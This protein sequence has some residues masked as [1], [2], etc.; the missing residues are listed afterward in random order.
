M[1][2]RLRLMKELSRVAVL[3][4]GLT[5]L[6]GSCAESNSPVQE[7]DSAQSP[8]PDA[9]ELSLAVNY[10]YESSPGAS[11]SPA[12]CLAGVVWEKNFYTLT[13]RWNKAPRDPQP[14]EALEGVV[15]PG[16]N[17]TGGNLEPDT[18]VDAWTIEGVDSEIAILV[19]DS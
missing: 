16:C 11:I 12:A 4:L 13:V 2:A 3:A 6:L 17:D 15:I 8:T 14:D 9:S 18:P 1:F 10:D 19:E 7:T 5:V